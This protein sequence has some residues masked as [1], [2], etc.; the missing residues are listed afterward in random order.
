MD[1][2][3]FIDKL[4]CFAKHGVFK[5]EN[6]LGQKFLVS[7]KMEVNRAVT[8]EVESCV[9]YGEVC[10]FI[11]EYMKNNTFKLIETLADNLAREILCRFS[12]HS[13][14]LR[15][16]K[17]WAPVGLP[18]ESVGVEIKRG[19]HRAYI[20]LGSN[21]GD[22]KGHI[23]RGVKELRANKYIKIERVSNLIETEPYGVRE[24]DC[25]LNGCMSID[26][27]LDPYE[28]LDELNRIEYLEKRE[29]IQHWGP[30]TLDL[31]ILMYDDL[32][33]D[34]ERL[35]IPH[36]DMHNRSFVLEPLCDIA[37]YA[38]HSVFGKSSLQMLEELKKR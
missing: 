6:V 29:R 34:D 14:T 10:A 26:T 22:K 30:R 28:L 23:E 16:D 13:I 3:V 2:C 11:T 12:I 17:P 19:W 4:Q 21:M 7:A 25:F 9:N 27:L 38:I 5:E 24:Q 36:I 37:P 20:A 31:D 8:D 32:I 33:I 1:N 15:I 18:F 35:T